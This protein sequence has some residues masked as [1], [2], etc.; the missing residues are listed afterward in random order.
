MNDKQF[1][2]IKYDRYGLPEGIYDELGIYWIW[3]RGKLV[4]RDTI[5]DPES[6]YYCLEMNIPESL[7]ILVDGGYITQEDADRMRF[8]QSDP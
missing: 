7:W 8:D 6:G 2:Y 1:P 5:D 3:Y 4:A